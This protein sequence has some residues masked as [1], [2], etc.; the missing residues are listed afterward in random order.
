MALVLLS[1]FFLRASCQSAPE[2]SVSHLNTI[3]VQST[4]NTTGVKN[5]CVLSFKSRSMK[6]TLGANGVSRDKHEGD[7]C[8]PAGTF[9]LRRA[10][11]RADKLPSDLLDPSLYPTYLRLNQTELSYGWCDDS[12]S[13]NYNTFV[14]LP[15]EGGYSAEHLWLTDSNVYDLLAVIGYND[16]PVVSGQGSAIFFHV[17]ES[18]GPTAGCVALS[19]DDLQWVLQNTN[20][21]TQMQIS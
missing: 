18:Y 20:S 16:D 19:I 2:P 10:F 5:S 7:G 3:V 1:A 15:M 17:T 13:T 9:P 11:Y 12:A 6:C 8:T 4:F 14:Q 21:E